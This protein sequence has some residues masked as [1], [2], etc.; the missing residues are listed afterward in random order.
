MELKS[1]KAFTLLEAVITIS[2]LTIVIGMTAVVITNMV[3]IQKATSTQ[4]EANDEISNANKIANEYVSFVS[5]R[6][7]DIS[8][9]YSSSSPTSLTFSVDTYDFSLRYS[10]NT[11]SYSCDTEYLGDNEY[12][13]K[14]NSTSLNNVEA[15]SFTYHDDINMLEMDMTLLGR[16]SH[17]VYTLR[18]A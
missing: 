6:D 1:R 7:S 9:V 13:K 4:Y 2:I 8:F 11:L 17:H 16:V 5:V 14:S 10:N 3:T 15:F 12:L 18:T